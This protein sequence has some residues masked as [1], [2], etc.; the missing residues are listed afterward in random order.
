MPVGWQGCGR[1]YPAP[2]G[3]RI[4]QNLD[5]QLSWGD[6]RGC[7]MSRCSFPPVGAF[8][9][10]E[11]AWGCLGGWQGWAVQQARAGG[12]GGS[13]RRPRPAPG[14]SVLALGLPY[15][16]IFVPSIRHLK[17]AL[18]MNWRSQETWDAR[19]GG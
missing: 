6:T 17:H 5:F 4:H 9:R 14:R 18:G 13:S 19:A 8:W 11:G 1:G 16:P 2:A 3:I 10:S 15:E 7:L 12:P